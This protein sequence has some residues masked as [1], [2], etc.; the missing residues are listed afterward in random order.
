MSHGTCTAHRTARAPTYGSLTDLE[1]AR[2][3][4]SEMT[5]TD[6]GAVV[7][8]GEPSLSLTSS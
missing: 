7:W 2:A 8:L 5:D 6:G 4:T 3:M 1:D